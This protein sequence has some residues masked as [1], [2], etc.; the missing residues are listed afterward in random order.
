MA[1]NLT[2]EQEKYLGLSDEKQKDLLDFFTHN[3]QG[4]PNVDQRCLAV[5]R[6]HFETAFMFLNKAIANPPNKISTERTGE[7]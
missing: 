3:M 7:G 2:P 4:G 1:R 5:A 6:T